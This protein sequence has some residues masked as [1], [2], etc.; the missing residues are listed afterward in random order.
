MPDASPGLHSSSLPVCMVE[1]AEHAALRAVRPETHHVAMAIGAALEAVVGARHFARHRRQPASWCSRRCC[2]PRSKLIRVRIGGTGA[3]SLPVRRREEREAIALVEAQ[4]EMELRALHRRVHHVAG[5]GRGA[6]EPAQ[7]SARAA[8]RKH[9]DHGLAVGMPLI[10]RPALLDHVEIGRE[11]EERDH[12]M[13]FG[14]ARN[15]GPSAPTA[16]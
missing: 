16:R 6:A 15:R 1:M 2:S 8:A 3:V 10:E 12:D 11:R 14:H 9:R 13:R 5:A 7:S 4:I